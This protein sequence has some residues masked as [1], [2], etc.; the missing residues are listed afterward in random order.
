LK[1]INRLPINSTNYSLH[2]AIEARSLAKSKGEKFV[3]TNGCFDILH[4]GHALALEAT[5]QKG[6][7]LWVG[8][9]SDQ[10]IKNI[11]GSERPII[12][13]MYRA[14]L[15]ASLVSVSGVFIFQ[16]DNISEEIAIL[17]PDV[18]VKSSD[19]TLDTLDSKERLSLEKVGAVVEFVDMVDGLSTS[20]IIEK[21][22][23]NTT[24]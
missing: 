7:V 18:Y 22:S 21:I 15:L 4:A 1:A 9:N 8:I 13:E 14:Y 11:K 24:I 6:D 17:S 19:Y 10:S 20:S 5:S 16:N 23:Q 2:H 12:P 3:L